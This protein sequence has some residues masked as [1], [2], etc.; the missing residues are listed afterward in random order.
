MDPDRL[1]VDVV[2]L[3]LLDRRLGE[4]IGDEA[5][6]RERAGVERLID[7]FGKSFAPARATRFFS[8]GAWRDAKVYLR[9]T[10]PIGASIDGP[11]LVIEPHQTIVVEQGWRATITPKNPDSRFE[12]DAPLLWVEGRNLM[13][14]DAV[15]APFEMVHAHSTIGG[16]PVSGCFSGSTNGLASGN[17]ILEAT[18][19]WARR[20][21]A[22]G[23][24]RDVGR[25]A[26]DA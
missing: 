9:E 5:D 13:D 23:R 12:G 4:R 3:G 6:A 14:G 16:P 22:G 21:E 26:G 24:S 19:A 7:A 10:L 8:K 15:W 17:H 25:D 1:P 18:A 20:S 11:A 2:G